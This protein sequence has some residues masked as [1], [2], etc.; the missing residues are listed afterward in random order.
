VPRGHKDAAHLHNI[1][2]SNP[3]WEP[4]HAYV[5]AHVH[6]YKGWKDPRHRRSLR[7][8]MPRRPPPATMAQVINHRGRER[9][10]IAG[11][12]KSPSLQRPIANISTPTKKSKKKKAKKAL[13]PTRRSGLVLASSWS[14]HLSSYAAAFNVNKGFRIKRSEERLPKGHKESEHLH[15]LRRSNPYAGN[16]LNRKIHSGSIIYSKRGGGSS[17]KG[18]KSR[19]HLRA[20]WNSNPLW[21]LKTNYFEWSPAKGEPAQLGTKDHAHLNHLRRSNPC[22]TPGVHATRTPR[23]PRGHKDWRHMAA[24]SRSDPA[25]VPRGVKVPRGYKDQAHMHAIGRSNPLW[26]PNTLY[27]NTVMMRKMHFKGWMNE[28]HQRHQAKSRPRNFRVKLSP[29]I[30]TNFKIKKSIK[31]HKDLQHRRHQN[32][33]TPTSPR[34]LLSP[35]NCP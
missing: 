27:V 34:G 6:H 16:F 32:I 17:I 20:L 23:V 3:T 12:P 25:P 8:S 31:G 26:L 2:R 9:V 35:I 15:A 19:E 5:K 10:S 24:L 21:Q 7:E 18:I 4:N 30:S 33:S 13:K 29:T 1:G 22:R 28:K 11:I 14:G